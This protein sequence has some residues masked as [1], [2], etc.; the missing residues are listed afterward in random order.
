MSN[1]QQLIQPL[2]MFEPVECGFWVVERTIA[3]DKTTGGGMVSFQA[4]VN[5]RETMPVLQAA[6]IRPFA[7]QGP[8][9]PQNGLRLRADVHILFDKGYITVTPDLHVK[10]SKKIKE[11]SENGKDYNK[12]HCTLLASVPGSKTVRPS[13]EFLEWHNKAV[14]KV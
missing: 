11:E 5:G 12:Y 9:K 3:A 2:G 1:G 14:Y 6:H 13:R 10:V 8:N 7:E 4:A